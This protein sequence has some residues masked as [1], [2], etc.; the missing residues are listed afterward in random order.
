MDANLQGD[1]AT[2]SGVD[3]AAIGAHTGA[4][5]AQQGGI[6]AFLHG[7]AENAVGAIVGLD[8]LEAHLIDVHILRA[9]LGQQSLGGVQVGL[10]GFLDGLLPEGLKV[11]GHHRRGLQLPGGEGCG[12][13][14]LVVLAID[15]GRH[16]YAIEAGLFHRALEL[17]GAV[18]QREA[19]L[20][21]LIHLGPCLIVD[22]HIFDERARTAH[23]HVELGRLAQ[24]VVPVL[25][26]GLDGHHHVV[27]PYLSREWQQGHEGQQG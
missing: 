15:V 16:V 25:M 27:A 9:A 5:H 8:V 21:G 22:L 20:L 12:A 17:K 23:L 4:R 6:L 7:H 2:R 1:G 10:S 11:L 3:I 18:F 19:L 13:G 14:A 26:V 24:L